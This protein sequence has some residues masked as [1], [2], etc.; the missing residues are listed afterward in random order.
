MCFES[1]ER[2]VI[3]PNTLQ[4]LETITETLDNPSLYGS[5]ISILIIT[6]VKSF[7]DSSTVNNTAFGL[8]EAYIHII[9]ISSF[10]DPLLNLM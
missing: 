4:E 8:S 6:T 2:Q 3:I 5:G 1:W 10:I 7:I 9:F